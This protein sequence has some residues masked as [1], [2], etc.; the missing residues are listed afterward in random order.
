MV[1]EMKVMIKI[2]IQ[3]E[4]KNNLDITMTVQAV[5]RLEVDCNETRR[6]DLRKLWRRKL[7]ERR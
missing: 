5:R 2:V 1:M 7:E 6:G 3:I 4:I